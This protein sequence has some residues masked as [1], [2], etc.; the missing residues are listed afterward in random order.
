MGIMES[1]SFQEKSRVVLTCLGTFLGA[2]A[3]KIR[4]KGDVI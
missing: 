4:R 1:G 2:A 3:G